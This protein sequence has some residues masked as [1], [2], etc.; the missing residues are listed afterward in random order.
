MAALDADLP[1]EFWAAD[2]LQALVERHRADFASV[3][4]LS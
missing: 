2:A 3:D 1:D 4:R